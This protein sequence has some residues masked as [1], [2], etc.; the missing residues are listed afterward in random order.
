MG[1]STLILPVINNSV[2]LIVFTVIYGLAYGGNGALLAPLTADLFGRSNINSVFGLLA[3]SLGLTGLVSPY[4]AGTAHD[5]LGT[6]TPI[7][8]AAGLAALIGASAVA[9]ANHLQT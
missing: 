1:L 7:F 8:I 3:M 4:I 9:I 5:A 2:T 6:Y